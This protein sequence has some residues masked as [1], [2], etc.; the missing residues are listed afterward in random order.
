MTDESLTLRA[1]ARTLSGKQ[2][3]TLRASGALPVVVYGYETESTPLVVDAKAFRQLYE[4]AGSTGLVSLEVEGKNPVKILIHDVQ[5]GPVRGELI[6]ADLYAPNLKE[7]V[8]TEVPLEFVGEAAAVRELEGNMVT[9]LTELT[10][11]ALPTDLPHELEVDIRAL[12]TFDDLIHVSDV[13]VPAG[14]TIMDDPDV[15]I[16]LVTPPRSEEELKAEL[17]ADTAAAEQAAV[18][19]ID[20]AAEAEKAEQA[21][22]EEASEAPA[23]EQKSAE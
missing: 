9:N 12:K 21:E 10:V 16:A 20:E 1:E 22:G 14:V 23:E 19:A 8:E 5:V 2:V 13:V 3:K 17:E 11:R 15:V 18:G 4:Q 7:E 6:H